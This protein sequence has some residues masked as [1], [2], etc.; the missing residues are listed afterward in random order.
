MKKLL[1]PG[2]IVPILFLINGLAFGQAIHLKMNQPDPL[3]ISPGN[4]TTI[5]A[6]E[7]V[8]LGGDPTAS[9]GYENYIYNWEPEV[10]INDPTLANPVAA[11][12]KDTSY[13][14]TVT[15]NNNCSVDGIIKITVVSK[16]IVADTST[17]L[18][19]LPQLSAKG[20]KITWYGDQ[21]LK[22]SLASGNHFKPEVLQTGIYDYYLTQTISE[23]ESNP[24]KL[25]LTVNPLPDLTLTDKQTITK[26]DSAKLDAGEGFSQY[27]W[28]TGDTTQ[29]IYIRGEDYETGDH[30]FWVE[31]E[32]DYGC[33][34]SDTTLVTIEKSSG[35]K[36]FDQELIN[37]YPNPNTGKL[38]I[39]IKELQSKSIKVH[40]HSLAGQVVYNRN[41]PD[42]K[43]EETFKIDL[44]DQT[45]GIYMLRL[46]TD[47]TVISRKIIL[48]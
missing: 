18:G 3:K 6:G 31:V 33:K 24:S 46:S 29:T 40:L 28:N 13:K 45:P 15:D 1:I 32:N 27:H 19:S 5:K 22:D 47:H 48:K 37:I 39:Q 41:I 38:F 17:C 26:E 35:L 34:S 12:E 23:V 44:S 21:D 20:K 14:L 36:S 30:K 25:T 9:G 16:P 42:I 2:F 7:N 10:Y 43:R 8:I 4:D 11:P